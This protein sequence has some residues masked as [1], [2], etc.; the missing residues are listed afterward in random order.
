VKA[1]PEKKS[2][3]LTDPR[4]TDI[5]QGNVEYKNAITGFRIS[6]YGKPKCAAIKLGG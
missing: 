6:K 1:I 4:K 3:L 5:T 2:I